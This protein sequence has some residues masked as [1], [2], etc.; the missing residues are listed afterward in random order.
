M[1][2]VGRNWL[3]RSMRESKETNKHETRHPEGQLSHG[4][5]PVRLVSSHSIISHNHRKSNEAPFLSP[6]H[7][8]NTILIANTHQCI[9]LT[10]FPTSHSLNA[11]SKLLQYFNRTVSTLAPSPSPLSKAS[12]TFCSVSRIRA[13]FSSLNLSTVLSAFCSVAVSSS[14]CA[15]MTID[16]V[17]ASVGCA[18]LSS[19]VTSILYWVWRRY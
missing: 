7:V 11:P 6:T 16:S 10:S 9:N 19:F 1:T 4:K 18:E 17:S 14:S 12:P 2:V 13:L 15:S 8:F 3:F 5:M